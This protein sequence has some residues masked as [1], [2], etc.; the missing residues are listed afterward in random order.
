[1]MDV[2]A[3]LWVFFL[4]AVMGIFAQNAVF[5]RSLGVSRL[6]SLVADPTMDTVKYG[7]LLLAVQ[8]TAAPFGWLG[9]VRLLPL[10]GSF[11]YALRPLVYL[12]GSTLSLAIWHFLLK[13][14]F[15][16]QKA[17]ELLAMLPLAVYNCC[18]LGTLLVAGSQSYSLV[19]SVGF[20]AGSAVGYML[21]ALVVTEGQRRLRSRE[22]PA[23]FRGLPGTLVYIGILSL[24]IYSATGHMQ[25]L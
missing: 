18:V 4:Y 23:A 9:A 10:T 17:G 19:E 11:R 6:L 15:H 7:L 2:F 25:S 22:M 3:S 13:R 20:A 14:V 8:V 21:A 24:A 1:M 12:A 16:P 5:T